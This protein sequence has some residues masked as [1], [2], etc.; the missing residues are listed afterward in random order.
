VT[1]F[2]ERLKGL[3]AKAGLSQSGLATASGLSVGVIHDYEQ[4]RREPTLRSA[5]QLAAALGVDCTAFA[6]VGGD[7]KKAAKPS[8][9]AARQGKPPKK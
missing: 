5:I 3:R 2:A 9:L 7:A 6:D 4:G 1:S 8:K